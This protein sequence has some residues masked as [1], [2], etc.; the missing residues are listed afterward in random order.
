MAAGDGDVRSVPPRNG[1][2]LLYPQNPQN[3]VPPPRQPQQSLCHYAAVAAGGPATVFQ[4]RH[5]HDPPHPLPVK[6]YVLQWSPKNPYGDSS[7]DQSLLVHNTRHRTINNH[8]QSHPRHGSDLV[9]GSFPYDSPNHHRNVPD[10][11]SFGG[12]PGSN[13]SE[14]RRQHSVRSV[15]NRQWDSPGGGSSNAEERVGKSWM[16]KQQGSSYRPSP[17][18]PARPP[19]GYS[20]KPVGGLN[21]HSIK[22]GEMLE[23]SVDGNRGNYSKL[24]HLDERGRRMSSS[25]S[26][27]GL[28]DQLGLP[29]GSDI[30]SILP[31]D[32]E[33]FVSPN[34]CGVA[35]LVDEPKCQ[36]QSNTKR[37]SETVYSR[38]HDEIDKLGEDL[39][40]RL[41]RSIP[42]QP[43]RQLQ[44]SAK[45][46]QRLEQK[47][48]EKRYNHGKLN[49]LN[50]NVRRKSTG[51]NELGLT[52][53]PHQPSPVQGRKLH[54]PSSASE[55][56]L[57]DAHSGIIKFVNEPK[58]QDK[59]NRKK[60]GKSDTPVSLNATGGD[61]DCHKKRASGG[62]ARRRQQRGETCTYAPS[63][64]TDPPPGVQGKWPRGGLRRYSVEEQ[65]RSSH[66]VQRKEDALT[67]QN[68]VDESVRIIPTG[69]GKLG[70][71]DQLYLPG[72]PAGS[73]LHLVSASEIEELLSETCCGI[74][75]VVDK[76]EFH[77]QGKLGQGKFPLQ[78]QGQKRLTGQLNHPGPPAGS[79]LHFVSASLVEE[80]LSEMPLEILDVVDKPKQQKQG[81]L[82]LT[83]QLDHPGP[84]GS[85]L[86]LVSASEN[87]EL[88]SVMHCGIVEVVDR[89]N[90]QKQ[91]TARRHK[92]S[93]DRGGH[94]PF[95]DKISRC[96]V[97]EDKS[98]KKN[99]RKQQRVKVNIIFHH[100]L[101]IKLHII[102][103]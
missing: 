35:E 94:H 1:R 14:N 52:D 99:S 92:G 69:Q 38:F 97:I 58:L 87:E 73:D 40:G 55:E 23:H 64:H 56:L 25:P 5:G 77:K 18:E 7:Q 32:S 95:G 6:N 75:E 91:G 20:R 46:N 19:S 76:P 50:E 85:N 28:S 88:L 11:T 63:E 24:N 62:N 82:G 84:P 15:R 65:R 39:R 47:M 4:P 103:S 93:V 53:Q 59:G 102:H 68:H 54:L 26:E 57:S 66:N 30:C 71:A 101:G 27:L 16:R 70:L 29:A 51:D 8:F 21:Q 83:D 60:D 22:K 79:D 100:L 74:V 44:G 86:H 72:P 42:S 67:E 48:G 9:F 81:K 10:E 96:S 37:D 61:S 78:K 36:K 41:Y 45:R 2:E 34:R 3:I 98:V 49:H 89:P 80:L 90:L 12:F 17:R 13:E 43:S 33:V 31:S